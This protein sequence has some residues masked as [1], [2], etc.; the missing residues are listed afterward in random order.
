MTGR[1]PVARSGSTVVCAACVAAKWQLNS[2]SMRPTLFGLASVIFGSNLL[3]GQQPAP[4]IRSPANRSSIIM[5]GDGTPVIT[6]DRSGTSVGVYVRGTLYVFDAGP[7]VIRRIMEAKAKLFP[8]EPMRLG[9][10]FITHLHSDHTL[11]LPALLYYHPGGPSLRVLGPPGI[12]NMMDHIAMAW[13]EDRHIRMGPEGR[14]SASMLPMTQE[15][16]TGVVFRDSNV[17]VKAFEVQHGTWPHSL[18]YRVE[19][20]DRVIVISGDTRPTNA[21]VEACNGCDVLLHEVYGRAFMANAP[22]AYFKAFHTS[23][24]ELGHI[25][26]RARPGLLVMYHQVFRADKPADL[27]R[28]VAAQFHG[29][30]ISARDL[31]VY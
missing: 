26:A 17:T 31:D 20:P 11:G 22:D 16:G 14:D 25:A 1:E 30:V 29:P 15:I 13:A 24:P 5:L 6:A 7:G 19:T 9:P 27:L 21:I 28:E 2:R 4:N 23:G 10:V 18:A 12:K 3:V 8:S